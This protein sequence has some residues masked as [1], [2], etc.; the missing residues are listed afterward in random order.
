M[1]HRNNHSSNHTSPN[2]ADSTHPAPDKDKEPWNTKSKQKFETYVSLETDDAST[3][4]QRGP[5][6]RRAGNQSPSSTIRAK[7]RRS[8]VTSV[9]TAMGET[10]P[11]VESISSMFTGVGIRAHG[12]L[13][14][15]VVQG[16]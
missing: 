11:C 12:L 14:A 7:K 10:S 3:A 9:S 5:L 6:T 16:I 4:Q 2:M 8:E 1:H 13:G 15:D